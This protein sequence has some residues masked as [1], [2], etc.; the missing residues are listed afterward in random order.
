MAQD[1]RYLPIPFLYASRGLAAR[2]ETDRVPQGYFL[3]ILNGFEREESSLS[4]RY[5][6]Q[7]INRDPSSVSPGRNYFFTSPVTSIARMIYQGNPQRYAGL[8]DGTLWQR[9]SNSQGAYSSLALPLTAQGQPTSLSGQLFGTLVSSCYESSLPYLFVYDSLTSIKIAAGSSTPE[10]TGIDPSPFTLNVNPYAPLLLLID[11]FSA[12]N[13]YA[14]DGLSSWG[15]GNIETLDAASGQLI[16]D[17]SQFYGIGPS[18]GGGGSSY[19]PGP[20]SEFVSAG[21]G[22]PRTTVTHYSDVMSWSLHPIVPPTGE[23]AILTATVS[24]SISGLNDIVG[25]I[26]YQY[27]PDAGATWTT[28][29]HLDASGPETFPPIST[30]VP[31]TG[32]GNLANLQ[33]RIEASATVGNEGT[34]T[35]S[36]YIDSAY[37]VLSSPGAFGPVTNGM[38]AVLNSNKQ[39]MIPISQAVSQNL[40]DGI[41]T[42][43]LV[44]TLADHLLSAS[45]TMAIYASSNDLVDGFYQVS[46]VTASNS[47]L[48][49]FLSA[50]Q[51]GAVGGYVTYALSAS[52]YAPSPAAC[53]LTNQYSTPYPSQMTAWGFYEWVPPTTTTFPIGA[54]SGTIASASSTATISVTANFDLNQN[55]QV[56]D[57][58]LIVL[59]LL[60]S[61]PANIAQ[62]ELQ[63][64]VGEGTNNYY[65]A[66]ISPAYFQGA[67][68]GN[69]LA[70][71]TTQNQILADALGLISGQPLGTTTAQLQP[72]NFSTGSGSWQA[73]LI[74]RGN[75]LPVGQAGQ[76]GVDWSNVTGWQLS[77]TTNT[78]GGVS[79]SVNGLYLQW[80]YGPSSFGGIGYDWRQTYYN[81]AT[82]TESSPSPE[83]QF[84]QDFGYLASTSAPFFLRQAAQVTGQYSADPQVTHVRLYRRGGILASNWFLSVQA[85]NVTAS[86]LSGGQFVLKDVIGDA[87]LTQAQP[88]ALDNDPPVT[89][90]LVNPIQTTLLAATTLSGLSSIYSLFSPQTVTVVQSGAEFVPN[91]LVEIGNANNLEVVSV[92]TGGTG[93]FSAILRL[94][95]NQG[96]PV[97]VQAIPRQAC[98][99]CALSNQGGVTQAWLAGDPNNPHYLYYSKPRY[100][101]NFS[102]AGYIPVS[103][104]DDPIMAVINWRGTIVVGTTKTWYIIVGGARPYPQPTGAAHGMASTSWCLAEGEIWFQSQD[105]WRAF[106]GSDGVYQ[107]LPVEWMFRQS[108]ATIV[109]KFDPSQYAQTILCQYQNQVYGSFVSASN[110]FSTGDGER[111]RLRFDMAGRRF[112]LDDLPATAML[113]EQDTNA[114]LLGIEISG[115]PSG[116]NYA[117]VQDWQGDYDDGG[118]YVTHPSPLETALAQLPIN[119]AI[120]TPYQDLGKPHFPKQWNQLEGDYNTQNQP[121][122]TTLLFKGEEDFALALP[123]ANT[124]FL[125]GKVQY[126]I[127]Q[128]PSASNVAVGGV[129]AYSMSVL[130]QMAVTVAPTL[131]QENIY[132]AVLADERTSLDTYVQKFGTG[133][134]NLC[135]DS[136]FDYSGTSQLIVSVYADGGNIP[137]YVDDF[138]LIPQVNRAAVRVQF[139]ARKFRLWR[140]TVTSSQP[141][142]LWA[143]VAVEV[144]ALEDGSGFEKYEFGIYEAGGSG[145]PG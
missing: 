72:T 76:A 7:I 27:S 99:L 34:L 59:T 55:N 53:V 120:Q 3:N 36:G 139:P 48:I 144:K 13:T 129:E 83:M 50:N 104:P 46:E 18:G 142:Q 9:N 103:S 92:I 75:F 66:F 17:F 73:C 30:S 132:A 113:W 24:G 138:T 6:Y 127:T 131:F 20:S 89:S 49:P 102:P 1:S 110:A 5:G 134:L 70:Y 128:Q 57:S 62:A 108:P 111:F 23:T 143:P 21:N 123:A 101:E 126:D 51:I 84:N 65:S 93:Q 86:G 29:Y 136:Y 71:Q 80:G 32:L 15:W 67:I 119:L 35:V 12:S 43:L 26:V 78:N 42:E 56:T 10:L 125:R 22:T 79:F 91:M 33:I 45:D 122:Q 31:I 69:Q 97:S 106:S 37:V 28:F 141:F 68:A 61:N 85:P 2:F 39:A 133:R 87:F 64:Y 81:A 14:A 116:S 8:A 41:Y 140:M 47:F 117:I 121:I 60:T 135:L 124:G 118:W 82:G 77:V 96:E 109:P 94:Q 54:W 95:H 137:Y 105:G 114:L 52:D 63:F 100:P 88:L 4:S 44:Q 130:H 112:G 74:P 90:S 11:N 107:T 25:S 145:A 40:I 115:Q 16:T 98:S 19:S 38:L 58:D